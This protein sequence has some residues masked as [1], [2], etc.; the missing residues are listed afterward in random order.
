MVA[1]VLDMVLENSVSLNLPITHVVRGKDKTGRTPTPPFWT[2][3][4]VCPRFQNN[5]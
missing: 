4:D 5:G 3:D 2:S 1:M